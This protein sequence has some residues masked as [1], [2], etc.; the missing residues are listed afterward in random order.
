MVQ[1]KLLHARKTDICKNSWRTSVNYWPRTSCP[2][3]PNV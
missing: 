3:R 2:S 1:A